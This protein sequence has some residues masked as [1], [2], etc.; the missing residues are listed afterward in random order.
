MSDF[1]GRI[2]LN[3]LK[4]Y[5]DSNNAFALAKK[6]GSKEKSIDIWKSKN[7]RELAKGRL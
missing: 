5:A 6:L 3:G 4:R 2:S 1:D 7:D